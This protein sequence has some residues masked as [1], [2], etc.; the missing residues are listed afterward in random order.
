M[1][2]VGLA[3]NVQ[4]MPKDKISG[5]SMGSHQHPPYDYRPFEEFILGVGETTLNHSDVAVAVAGHDKML[6]GQGDGT[7]TL[8]D[9][10]L[11]SRF[12]SHFDTVLYTDSVATELRVPKRRQR[13]AQG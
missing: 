5:V 8:K 1:L 9:S 13:L 4:H 2:S 10:R 3:L 7:Y 6:E 11:E 12:F